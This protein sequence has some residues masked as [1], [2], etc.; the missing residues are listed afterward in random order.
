MAMK[1]TSLGR[2]SFRFPKPPKSTKARYIDEGV[3]IARKLGR[4]PNFHEFNRLTK[5]VTAWNPYRLYG[6]DWSAFKRDIEEV[7]TKDKRLA[8]ARKHQEESE[9]GRRDDS[10]PAWLR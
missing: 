4:T 3:R 9:K 7:L 10:L 1:L 5:T 6:R 2:P 8:A